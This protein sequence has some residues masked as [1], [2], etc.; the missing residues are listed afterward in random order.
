[1]AEEKDVNIVEIIIS[2]DEKH[3]WLSAFVK[4]KV[5]EL[6]D[7][8]GAVFGELLGGIPGLPG[9]DKKLKTIKIHPAELIAVAKQLPLPVLEK[10]VK[11][12]NTLLQQRKQ[13]KP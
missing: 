4:V 11:D 10:V 7:L 9:G 13:S 12:L 6:E 8:F 3:E 1:M 2:R 5:E